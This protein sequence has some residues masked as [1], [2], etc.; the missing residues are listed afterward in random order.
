MP[1]G[2]AVI[3]TVPLRRM[4]TIA[5]W[6][7]LPWPGLVVTAPSLRDAD[8]QAIRI[9]F[10]IGRLGEEAEAAEICVGSE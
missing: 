1:H 7:R 9:I 5:G 4:S 6:L 8:R 10:G 2:Q 3:I